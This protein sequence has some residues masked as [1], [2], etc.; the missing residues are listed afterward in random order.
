MNL[1]YLVPKN[2]FDDSNVDKLNDLSSEEIIQIIPDLLEWIQDINWPIASSIIPILLKHQ[3]IIVQ[4]LIQILQPEQK[5]DVWKY[6]IINVIIK[7]FNDQNFQKVL[8]PIK[9]I[10]ITPTDGEKT[11]EVQSEAIEILKSHNISLT[12]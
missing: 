1:K 12:T 8:E 6:W 11:E 10:A 7:D 2:K 4:N 5:D 9:R 3:D